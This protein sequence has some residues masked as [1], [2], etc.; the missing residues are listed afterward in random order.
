[1]T[2]ICPLAPMGMK[3][4]LGDGKQTMACCVHQLYAAITQL[5]QS[6]PFFGVGIPDYH[7]PHFFPDYN[8]EQTRA[9]M[10]GIKTLSEMLLEV[11]GYGGNQ[12]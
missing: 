8:D 1:M 11:A 12:T 7:C 6:L 3:C 4:E 9:M 5:Q 10:E 2:E